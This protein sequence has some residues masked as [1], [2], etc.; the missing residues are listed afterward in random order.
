MTPEHYVNI[1]EASQKTGVAA[2]TLRAWERRYGLI[3]PL[4]TPKGHRLYSDDN[5][6]QINQ[7]LKWLDRGVAI[8]KVAALLDADE[9]DQQASPTTEAWQNEQQVLFSAIVELK[10]RNLDPLFAQLSKS[11]PF[12]SLCENVYLPVSEQLQGRWQIKH[13]GYQ[14]EQQLWQQCWQKQTML[15]AVRANKQ[16]VRASL[17]LVNIDAG[18]VT[19]DYWLSYGLLV[20]SGIR[21]NA[22]NQIEDLA[23]LPRLNKSLEQ[24]LILFGNNKINSKQLNQLI[25]IKAVW[26]DGIIIIGQIANIHHELLAENEIEHI[27]GDVTKCWASTGYQHW[28]DYTETNKSA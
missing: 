23:V 9:A 24:P 15:M 18:V 21:V 3:N 20:D 11:M 26:G 14:L 22:I 1:R 7:I 4:R 27:P 25:K 6:E 17:W 13:L 5:I 10:Q 8:S 16:P 12:Y 19:T 2:V 28:L